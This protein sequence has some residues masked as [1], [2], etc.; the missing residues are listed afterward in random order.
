MRSLIDAALKGQKG[1]L[2][3][4]TSPTLLRDNVL[5]RVPVFLLLQ[6]APV[7]AIAKRDASTSNVHTL[8]V[9]VRPCQMQSLQCAVVWCPE[10]TFS[11]WMFA[12]VFCAFTTLTLLCGCDR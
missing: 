6:L 9:Q 1:A 2:K 4:L 8:Q 10:R 11:L 3:W 7:A 5:R 12:L